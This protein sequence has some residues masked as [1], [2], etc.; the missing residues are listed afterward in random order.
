MAGYLDMPDKTIEAWRNLWFHTGDAGTMDAEGVVTFIDRIKDC[1][2]RRGENISAAEVEAVVAA[3]PGVAEVAAF[4]VPSDLPGGE[5]EVMLAIVAKP[6]ESLDC[7]ALLLQ[8][9]QLLPRF[10]RPRF[11]ELMHELPKTATGKVQRAVL[12]KRGA[13]QAWDREK[14]PDSGTA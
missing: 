2:R 9:D 5:D 13:A 8:A 1:I 10:A 12:R 3:L 7:K 14:T 6:A 11:L 4:A